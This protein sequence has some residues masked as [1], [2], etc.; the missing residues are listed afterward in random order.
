MAKSLVKRILSVTLIFILLVMPI[1]SLCFAVK[2]KDFEKSFNDAGLLNRD[3]SFLSVKNSKVIFLDEES[4]RIFI[5]V[6]NHMI[7]VKYL[8]YHTKTMD[9]KFYKKDL[10]MVRRFLAKGYYYPPE[11]VPYLMRLFFEISK[12]SG[13]ED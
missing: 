6:Y 2:D 12:E 11:D 8:N 4:K 1:Y 7:V 13:F 3:N 9:D 5:D 10:L